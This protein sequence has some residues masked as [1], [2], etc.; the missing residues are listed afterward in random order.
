MLLKEDSNNKKQLLARIA[1]AMQKMLASHS[2]AQDILQ[3]QQHLHIKFK[4][5]ALMSLLSKKRLCLDFLHNRQGEFMIDLWR[6]VIED[7]CLRRI[8]QEKIS[9]N[10]TYLEPVIALED[11]YEV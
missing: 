10:A 4:M 9:L 2:Q 8:I 1:T 11:D 3:G 6:H 7:E 5:T